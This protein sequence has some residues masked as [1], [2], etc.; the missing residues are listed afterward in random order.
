MPQILKWPSISL[1]SPCNGLQGPK[2]L[3][4]CYLSAFCYCSPFQLLHSNFL[5]SLLFFE[6]TKHVA[7]FS[8]CS[9]S[10]LCWMFFCEITAW[11][12]LSPPFNLCS[13]LK[14]PLRPVLTTLMTTATVPFSLLYQPITPWSKFSF[15]YSIYLHLTH[16]ITCWFVLFITYC[17]IPHF[18]PPMNLSSMRAAIVVHCCILELKTVMGK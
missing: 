3:A 13:N 17:F 7:A 1:R 8:L 2:W 16:Y 4:P 9:C 18:F 15:Y 6:H 12:I 11:P 14:L 10:S 5:A